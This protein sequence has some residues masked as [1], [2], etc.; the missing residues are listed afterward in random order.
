V[1][2]NLATREFLYVIRLLLAAVVRADAAIPT[3][4]G[5]RLMRWAEAY[6]GHPDHPA[7]CSLV[8]RATSIEC[9]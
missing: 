1:A 3:D 9:R 5:G 6:V 4:L 7:I 2:I 8:A